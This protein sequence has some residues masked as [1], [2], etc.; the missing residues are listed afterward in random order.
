MGAVKTNIGHTS[1]AA[2]VAGLVKV[3]LGL[4]HK[5]IPPSL[6]FETANERIR[7]AETPFYVN[8]QRIVWPT[9]AG[10]PR[11]GAV[12]SFGFSG[13]NVHVVVEEAPP[14]E[15][16]TAP[17]GW[18]VVAVS[19]RTP[20]ALQQRFRDLA[21]YLEADGGSLNLRDVSFTLNVGRQH[22]SARAAFVVEDLPDLCR[23]LREVSVGETPTT[24]RPGQ[25]QLP[26]QQ[27]VPLLLNDLA[28]A[29]HRSETSY[30][31]KLLALVALYLQ[32]HDVEWDTLYRDCPT[33]RVPL[34]AYPFARDRYWCDSVPTVPTTSAPAS[35][36]T[37]LPW[38]FQVVWEDGPLSEQGLM[39]LSGPFLLFDADQ[40]LAAFVRRH[41]P[42]ECVVRVSPGADFTW[43]GP[44]E[45]VIRPDRV[46]DY[47]HLAADLDKHGDCRSGSFIAGPGRRHSQ[48][49]I[50]ARFSRD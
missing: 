45:V 10:G 48:V 37:A 36:S 27:L 12:S 40:E 1:A 9:V 35:P 47:Q 5:E 3:L 13:V 46:N 19:A 7:F 30:R 42:G 15:A 32:G 11:R 8:T 31:E 29:S 16:R 26:Y 23:Q 34:P 14:C 20:A 28:S 33:W 2:G 4:T 17:P 24:R 21:E 43:V 38:L 49:A 6:H 18:W 25:T 41:C 50:R 39:P 44:D 22:W